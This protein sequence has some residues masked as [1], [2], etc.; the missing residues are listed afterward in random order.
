MKT[1]AT[2]A[3]IAQDGQL[4]LEVPC[5]LPPGPVEIVLVIQPMDTQP[6]VKSGPPYRSIYGLWAGM[7][8]DI[9]VYSDLQEMNEKWE[10]SLEEPE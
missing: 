7:L 5:D 2:L 10:N 3:Q 1:L 9:D 4:R 6:T 8:P